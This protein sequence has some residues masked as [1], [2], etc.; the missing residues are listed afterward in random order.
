MVEQENGY[1][2]KRVHMELWQGGKMRTL[3]GM[4][5]EKFYQKI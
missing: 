1:T 2:R 5:N 3:R 4:K